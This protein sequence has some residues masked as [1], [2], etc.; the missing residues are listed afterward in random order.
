MLSDDEYF[1]KSLLWLASQ[2]SISRTKLEDALG[3]LGGVSGV[4]RNGYYISAYESLGAVV[5]QEVT[6]DDLLEVVKGSEVALGRN[7]ECMYYFIESI[8][9]HGLL[10]G[11][12]AE[13]LISVAPEGCKRFLR[14]RF[15]PEQD[16]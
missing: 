10:Q 16:I 14:K 1:K 3:D 6:P 12:S 7:V 2:F 11:C 5:V 13:V 8:V 9:D 4:I 15:L